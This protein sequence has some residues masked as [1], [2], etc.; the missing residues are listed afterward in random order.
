MKKNILITGAGSGI[1]FALAE[2]YSLNSYRSGT[3]AQ[4]ILTDRDHDRLN[5]TRR[6][7]E[8]F[9]VKVTSKAIDV[10]DQTEMREWLEEVDKEQPI[11]LL[12]AN[13]GMA[14]EEETLQDT[15]DIFAVNVDGSMHT[16]MPVLGRM[17]DDDKGQIAVVSSLAAYRPMP[18]FPAYAKAKQTTMRLGLN[19][20]K[21]FRDN[22]SQ[23]KVNVICP[24]FVSTPLEQAVKGSKPFKISASK[25]AR[26]IAE[27]LDKDKA[28]ITTVPQPVHL[29]LRK[30]SPDR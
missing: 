15:A 25:A 22:G 2:Y 30:L 4:L 23:V 6:F 7:C 24:G 16:I 20:R 19:L 11:D 21:T 14:N 27:G 8:N 9:G 18:E 1:G 26:I 17:L 10:R 29:A 5:Q 13:A 28:I 3:K 12:I